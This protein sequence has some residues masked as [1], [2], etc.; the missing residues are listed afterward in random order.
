VDRARVD[1][2]LRDV[3]NR[4]RALPDV[5]TSAKLAVLVRRVETAVTV[6]ADLTRVT[7]DLAN[8]AAAALEDDPWVKFHRAA[9]DLHAAATPA[10]TVDY[11]R[12]AAS[13]MR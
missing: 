5:N 4:V 12:N 2:L 3:K 13:D 6:G 10:T 7:T 11:V 9:V 8:A 1:D